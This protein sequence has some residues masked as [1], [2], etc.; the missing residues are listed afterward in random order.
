MDDR[1]D[2]VDVFASLDRARLSR[3]EQ[4]AQSDQFDA[5]EALRHYVEAL[6]QDVQRSGEQPEVGDKYRALAI[7]RELTRTLTVVAFDVTHDTAVRLDEG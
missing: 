5:R 7:V 6:W 3:M 2:F 4:E 1:P